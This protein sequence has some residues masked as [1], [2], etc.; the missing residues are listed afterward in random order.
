MLLRALHA[1]KA[2]RN[3]SANLRGILDAFEKKT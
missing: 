3:E 1:S 2:S